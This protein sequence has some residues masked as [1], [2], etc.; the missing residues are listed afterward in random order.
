MGIKEKVL[1][2]IT[3]ILLVIMIGIACYSLYNKQEDTRKKSKQYEWNRFKSSNKYRTN[4]R[5][6]YKYSYTIIKNI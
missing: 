3:I 2:I 6:I 5:Y 1:M 4:W